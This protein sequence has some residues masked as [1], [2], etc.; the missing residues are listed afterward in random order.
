M[1]VP[2]ALANLVSDQQTKRQLAQAT[3][4]IVRRAFAS[5][6]KRS[7]LERVVFS[8]AQRLKRTNANVSLD[9]EM[10]VKNVTRQ[11]C[12]NVTSEIMAQGDYRRLPTEQVAYGVF[13]TE[14]SV[15]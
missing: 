14:V 9:E 6:K 13:D 5:E 4:R 2:S 8:Q 3:Q 1:I 10:L 15:L 12:N 7:I 11:I